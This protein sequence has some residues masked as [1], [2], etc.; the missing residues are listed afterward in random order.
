MLTIRW[1]RHGR[2]YEAKANEDAAKIVQWSI[3]A[4]Y[5]GDE[6]KVQ[7]WNGATLVQESLS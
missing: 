5:S 2:V 3:M 7:L 4:F 6:I 1:E